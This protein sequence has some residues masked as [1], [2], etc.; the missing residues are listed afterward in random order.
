MADGLT[1]KKVGI[2]NITDF[3]ATKILK[4]F[5]EKEHMVNISIFSREKERHY[6]PRHESDPWKMRRGQ[7]CDSAAGVLRERLLAIAP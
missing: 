2:T 1:Y 4:F 7:G 5:N 3:E 6:P